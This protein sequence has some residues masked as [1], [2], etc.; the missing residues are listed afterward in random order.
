MGA[1]AKADAVHRHLRQIRKLGAK[2]QKTSETDAFWQE[3][4][5]TL[6]QDAPRRPALYAVGF[7]DTPEAATKVGNLVRL[8]VKTSTG[9]PGVGDGTDRR[10]F[11]PGR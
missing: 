4:L 8:G 7:S 2:C 5:A 11:A 6:P 9:L 1:R 3:Y 10:T